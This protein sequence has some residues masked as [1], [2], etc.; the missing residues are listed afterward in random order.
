[1]SYAAPVQEA[2]EVQRTQEVRTTPQLT[3]V[4]GRQPAAA[5]EFGPHPLVT[6][7]VAM[8]IAFAGAATLIGSVVLC[9][10]LRHSG[11]MAP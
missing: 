1:M 10:A 4:S 5:A 6:V 3:L 11:V 7:F 2:Q 8:I 9:L